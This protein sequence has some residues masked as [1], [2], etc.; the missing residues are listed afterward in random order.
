METKP[1]YGEHA[2]ITDKIDSIQEL[3]KY[4]ASAKTPML[5]KTIFKVYDLISGS[6][7]IE[8]CVTL[9]RLGLHLGIVIKQLQLLF[10]VLNA[11]KNPSSLIFDSYINSFLSVVMIDH[12]TTSINYQSL[13]TNFAV[14]LNI[15]IALLLLILAV[16]VILKKR[17]LIAAIV[18]LINAGTWMA[19]NIF[20]FPLL[21][22][23]FF[24]IRISTGTGV[25]YSAYYEQTLQYS[26]PTALLLGLG[27]GI[28]LIH[29]LFSTLFLYDSRYNPSSPGARGFSSILIYQFL[30]STAICLL[31]T[32]LPSDYFL[33][34]GFATGL[35]ILS[36]YMKFQPY[37]S[38][39]E[40]FME[41]SLWLIFS[42]SCG[43]FFV[44]NVLNLGA[45]LLFCFISTIL[46][47]YILL[48]W[49][50]QDYRQRNLNSTEKT[51]YILEAKL[52]KMLYKTKDVSLENIEA[53]ETMFR[54]ATE[55][56]L[57]FKPIFV[58]EFNF[59]MQV[60]SNHSLAIIKLLKMNFAESR[61]AFIPKTG[62]IFKYEFSLESEYFR[63]VLRKRLTK[64]GVFRDFNLFKYIKDLHVFVK[65]D[66]TLCL[67]LLSALDAS[68]TSKST[69]SSKIVKE[70]NAFY[71]SFQSEKHYFKKNTKLYGSDSLIIECHNSFYSEVI[72]VPGNASLNHKIRESF[73]D[74]QLQKTSSGKKAML[75]V[76]GFPSTLGN[77][78]Y[79]DKDA[80]ELFSFPSNCSLTGHNIARLIPYPFNTL[81]VSI[82]CKILL[83]SKNLDVKRPTIFIRDYWDS[84]LELSMSTRVVFYSGI[85]YF[86]IEFTGSDYCPSILLCSPTLEVH[87]CSADIKN[88]FPELMVNVEGVFP[89]LK[90]YLDTV[91]QDIEF[92]YEEYGKSL[93]MKWSEVYVSNILVIVLYF[94]NPHKLLEFEPSQSQ[95]DPIVG[96]CKSTVFKNLERYNPR[97][98]NNRKKRSRRPS[99]LIF[100]QKA[101]IRDDS[102]QILRYSKILNT[103]LIVSTLCLVGIYISMVIIT[104]VFVDASALDN[105]M[106]DIINIKS[107]IASLTFRMRTLDLHYQGI[108]CYFPESQYLGIVNNNLQNLQQTLEN[109]NNYE[110]KYKIKELFTK[111]INF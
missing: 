18:F 105:M 76:S 81:H 44:D 74:R 83:Y 27:V 48:Y 58:W 64:I 9:K 22:Y 99:G 86:I 23:T 92:V 4:L 98:T 72:K 16:Q 89:H 91:P 35:I 87:V 73:I 96:F 42:T 33:G 63:Y 68:I 38:F 8:A 52:R 39:T 66:Y 67:N 85:P 88:L 5:K 34:I 97:S 104:L 69:P 100:S 49:Y 71:E 21:I 37:Y 107:N 46:P 31:Y 106:T 80:E 3:L 75:I 36:K 45:P 13:V 51:P 32:L 59:V 56:Y 1:D 10:L 14:F 30:Y 78:I 7:D 62:K 79:A 111:K 28:L 109:I 54:E 84:C 94:L 77:I 26:Q 95:P 47:Q 41:S 61:P 15:S 6:G 90:A 93:K 103:I 11:R 20:L 43:L 57:E 101:I 19:F 50:L 12:Y 55:T 110:S 53:I 40:N 65:A 24:Y 82:L 29:L 108:P 25:E 17:F 60:S 70:I 102:L 2:Q